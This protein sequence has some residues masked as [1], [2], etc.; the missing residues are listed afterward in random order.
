M[1]CRL[2]ARA[3]W[4]LHPRKN[5]RTGPK[6]DQRS[7]PARSG[8]RATT[9]KRKTPTP[10]SNPT[11]LWRRR[12]LHS[13]CLKV[14]FPLPNRDQKVTAKFICNNLLPSLGKISIPLVWNFKP[15]RWFVSDSKTIMPGRHHSHLTWTE[16]L[17]FPIIH[18][19]A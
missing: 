13:P 3:S 2:S 12:H 10:K 7:H 11:I 19:C 4:M 6:K 1:V 17:L 5:G 9:E 14:K 8:E 15:N 16:F 18:A